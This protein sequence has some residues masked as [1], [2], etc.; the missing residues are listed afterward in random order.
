VQHHSLPLAR[1]HDTPQNLRLV[2]A[3]LGEGIVAP[4]EPFL[5]FAPRAPADLPEAPFFAEHHLRVRA[6]RRG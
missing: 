4:D 1:V 3:W 5:P 2:E 6:V